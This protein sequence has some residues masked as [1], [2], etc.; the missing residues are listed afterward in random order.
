MTYVNADG[1]VM[2]RRS[3]LR[4]S[5]ITDAFWAVMDFIWFF[6]HS[7]IDPRAARS[8]IRPASRDSSRRGG[9]GGGGP[10]GGGPPKRRVRGMGDL[11]ASG[12]R[13]PVAGG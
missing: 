7:M 10:S 13:A 12:M 5:L 11:S 4:L 1:M 3:R 2:S 8:S 9:G 6:F